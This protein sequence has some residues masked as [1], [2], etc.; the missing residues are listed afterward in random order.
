MAP[1]LKPWRRQR[2]S[3][4]PIIASIGLVLLALGG[5][6]CLGSSPTP[7]ALPPID[8]PDLHNPAIRHRSVQYLGRPLVINV[9]A[10]TCVPCKKELPMINRV[11][12]DEVGTQFLGV[13]QLEFRADALAFVTQL[14]VRF[15]VALDESGELAVSL[16]LAGLP[17]TIFVDADGRER[18]RV[19]G[20]ITETTLRRHIHALLR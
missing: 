2:T 13:D 7:R 12:A 18:N 4:H 6:A 1:P 14:G 10:S 16:Q 9:F 19:T 20:P 8:L 15:P 3:G 5:A 17:T 11:A